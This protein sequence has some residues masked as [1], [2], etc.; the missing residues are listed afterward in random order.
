M[1]IYFSALV[2]IIGL[3]VWVLSANAKVSEAGR[4]AFFAG[5]FVFLLN[6]SPHLGV[7]GR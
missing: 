2:C 3:L 7:I 1:Q 6:G 4:L 5:L